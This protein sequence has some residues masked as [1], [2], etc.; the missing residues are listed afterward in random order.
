MEGPA[1]AIAWE[2]TCRAHLRWS[3]WTS[4]RG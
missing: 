2:I 3:R 4:S 1:V